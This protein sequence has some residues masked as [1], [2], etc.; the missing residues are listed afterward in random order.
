MLAESFYD[1]KLDSANIMLA[2]NLM[3]RFS[4]FFR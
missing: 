3:I 2:L 4:V 1:R